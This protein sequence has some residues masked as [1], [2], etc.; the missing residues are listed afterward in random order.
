MKKQEFLNRLEQLL[1]DMPEGEREEAM[2]YYSDYID[3]AGPDKEDEVISALGSP[4]E[5]AES[6]RNDS[7]E[8]EFTEQGYQ[9]KNA[10]RF[11]ENTTVATV[12]SNNAGG[13]E[14]NTYTGGNYTGGTYT[15]GA[16]GGAQSSYGNSGGAQNANTANGNAGKKKMSDGTLALTITLL[17]L[18]SPLWIPLIVSILG[19]IATAACSFV[20]FAIAGVVLLVVSVIVLIV[21]IV[22]L[23]TAW[24]IGLMILGVAFL[25]AAVGLLLLAVTCVICRYFIPWL[26]GCLKALWNKLFGKREVAGA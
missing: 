8:G 21:G 13:N 25:L 26:W 15:G 22:T 18:L 1:A 4:E 17:V 5:V 9:D 24:P 2:M 14:Q 10:D 23:F 3:D 11:K 12:D 16:A 20:G 7:R 19:M 6:I